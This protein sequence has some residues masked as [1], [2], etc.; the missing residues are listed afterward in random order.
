VGGGGRFDSEREAGLEPR[1]RR[2]HQSPHQ[3]PEAVEDEIVALRRKLSD[4]GL[5]AGAQTIAVHLE[6][7]HRGESIP[8][9][10][11]IWRILSRRGVVT[12]QP[13]KRPRSSFI[14]FSAEMPKIAGRPTS[15]TGVWPA[16]P[17]SR[18]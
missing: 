11:T 8:S 7:D 18:S 15:R 10:A 6:R 16:A 13:H 9:V 4:L 12:A 5:D 1:S 3:T 17:R 14:R 2:P